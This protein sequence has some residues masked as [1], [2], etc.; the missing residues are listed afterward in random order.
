V[1]VAENRTEGADYQDAA[2][3]AAIAMRD[4]IKRYV[5]IV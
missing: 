3:A 5:T 4:D 2:R 1:R